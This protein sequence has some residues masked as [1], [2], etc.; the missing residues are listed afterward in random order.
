[1]EY[2]GKYDCF[3]N[4]RIRLYPLSQRK[5]KVLGK[6]G[7]V[8]DEVRKRPIEHSTK[9]IQALARNV[10]EKRAKSKPVIWMTGAHLVKNTFGRLLRDL[11]EREVVTLVGMNMAGMIHD[12]ELALIGETSE[13]VV[14][15]LPKGEFGFARETG[16]LINNALV[17]GEKLKI[18]AGESLARLI[19]GEPF[20]EKI[21]F[22]F[23]E[24]SVVAGGYLAGKPITMHAGIGT[25]IIDEHPSWCPSAKG[26]CSGRDFLVFCAE[27]EKMTEGGV[28]L[29]VGTSV[30][31][32]EVF[33]KAVSMCANIEKPPTDLMTG[34]FDFRPAD[35]KD[36]DDERKSTYYFRDVKSV[37]VRIPEAFGGSGYYVQ[38]DHL[39]TVPA[40]YQHLVK[41]ESEWP[42]V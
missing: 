24:Y 13:V 6:N 9:E 30:T 38:G 25:D 2:Q 20:P 31:G 18:G 27:V 29:N 10:L 11:I 28:Y 33:L 5:N 23:P 26:G 34:C 14:E 35:P 16:E 36:V 3:D 39:I 15:A 17:H 32:P 12:L 22:K 40:F 7:V 4:Q 1:M 21:D 37:V 42:V 41:P 19:L 8:P